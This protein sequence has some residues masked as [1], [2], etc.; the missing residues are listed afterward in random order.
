VQFTHL[1]YETTKLS[2]KGA[3]YTFIGFDELTEFTE[4]QFFYLLSR[5]RSPGSRFRPWVRATTNPEYGSWVHR[6]IEWWI[7]PETGLPPPE[8]DGVI[9]HFIRDG[10]AIRWVA[11]DYRDDEGDGPMSLTFIASKLEDNVALMESGEGAEYRRK[12][13]ALGKVERDKLRGGS[14]ISRLRDGIFEHHTID[15][16]GIPFDAVPGHVYRRRLRYWD[17]A[18]T[19]PSAKNKDPDDTASCLASLDVDEDKG[20]TL[21]IFDSTAAQLEGDRKRKHMRHTA[22]KDGTDVEQ[23]IE[24][25]GGSSGKEIIRDYKTTHLAGW[26]VTGDRPRGSKV[27]RAQRWKPL[28]EVGRVVLVRNPDGTRGAWMDALLA[29]IEQFDGSNGSDR[30]RDRVDSVSGAYTALKKK[31]IKL[32][33]MRGAVH[34]S[35]RR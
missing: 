8:R 3:Q 14:W 20:E 21:Y 10:D 27:A 18:D 29:Q 17:L 24:Q 35:R 28:A 25:E 23:V 26:N 1:Q 11:E 4:G 9:R 12:L 30:K 13:K 5:A 33:R 22:T 32:P 15:R 34:T 7:D 31:V 16:Q 6:L 19:E 2:H